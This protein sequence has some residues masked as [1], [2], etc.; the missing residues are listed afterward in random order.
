V[1]EA[2]QR[3]VAL[4]DKSVLMSKW[5]LRVS[6]C[7]VYV[8]QRRWLG[9]RLK[10]GEV[11]ACLPWVPMVQQRCSATSWGRSDRLLLVSKQQAVESQLLTLEAQPSAS[12]TSKWLSA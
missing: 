5:C 11:E 1:L 4:L 12:A 9:L 3:L 6:R 8:S 7:P 10:L 2:A